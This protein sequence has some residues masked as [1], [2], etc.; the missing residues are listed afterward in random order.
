M[1]DYSKYYLQI[2]PSI[3]IRN[4][5][6]NEGPSS[7]SPELQSP[8]AAARHFPCCLLA[9]ISSSHLPFL[10]QA[11]FFFPHQYSPGCNPTSTTLYT[12]IQSQIHQVSCTLPSSASLSPSLFS[13]SFAPGSC[14]LPF[15]VPRFALQDWLKHSKVSQFPVVLPASAGL[16]KAGGLYR[17]HSWKG[18]CPVMVEAVTRE[19][20]YVSG[21]EDGHSPGR[22]RDTRSH[23]RAEQSRVLAPMTLHGIPL[24]CSAAPAPLT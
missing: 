9:S 2:S 21:R 17:A 5:L 20:E 6:F 12:S 14:F 24:H 23:G 11:S 7:P 4:M 13:L 15:S 1:P 18:F 22:P 16:R 19:P 3:R 8:Q 10:C